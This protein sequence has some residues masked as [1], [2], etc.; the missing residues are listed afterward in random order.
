M[1]RKTESLVHCS[2]LRHAHS[3][4]LAN[5]IECATASSTAI[6]EIEL[7]NFCARRFS[8]R[9]GH[10]ISPHLRVR[11]EIATFDA[12]VRGDRKRLA[13]YFDATPERLLR[14]AFGPVRLLIT[15]RDPIDD[16]AGF[17]VCVASWAMRSRH[18][19]HV[20]RV[21]SS[22]IVTCPPHLNYASDSSVG[23][24]AD[25]DSWPIDSEVAVGSPRLTRFPVI[26]SHGQ[27]VSISHAFR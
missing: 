25:Y 15:A 1:R 18:R 12:A 11:L 10:P 20:S 19:G 26:S 2:A 22:F 3:A 27:P 6:V 13:R 17:H 21:G 24:S 23:A 14:F 16:E 4:P 8:R 9:D 5:F 7:A